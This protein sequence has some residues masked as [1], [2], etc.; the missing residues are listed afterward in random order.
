MVYL[1]NRTSFLAATFD[2]SRLTGLCAAP[3]LCKLADYDNDGRDDVVIFHNDIN[4]HVDVS[5]NSGSS[6][7]APMRWVDGACFNWVGDIRR[8]CS[9]GDVDGD[10]LPD[11]VIADVSTRRVHVVRNG[12]AVTENNWH[13]SLC[14]PGHACMS[15]DFD[16]DGF[17]DIVDFAKSSSPA[18]NGDVF[19]QSSIA[20]Y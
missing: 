11:L 9:L 5:L 17:D 6:F 20:T 16:G 13:M 14:G 8:D 3:R 10:R 1:S 4:G 2:T 19:V 15:G 18:T 7:G 12:S